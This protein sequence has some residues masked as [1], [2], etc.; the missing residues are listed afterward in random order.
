[1]MKSRIGM[2]QLEIISDW[3]RRHEGHE[4]IAQ[5]KAEEVVFNSLRVLRAFVAKF[6]SSGL[7]TIGG[8]AA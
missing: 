1:M 2:S 4:G 3:P 8:L 6:S 5:Q 7:L